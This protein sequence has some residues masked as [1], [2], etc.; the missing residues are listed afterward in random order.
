MR[1]KWN[2]SLLS[3]IFNPKG[4]NVMLER[5]FQAKLI[6][7]IKQRFD[8]CMVIKNDPNYIQGLPDLLVLYR[9][10]WAALEC[11]QS[12]VASRRPN[13]RYYIDKMDSMS[14]ARFISPSNKEEV[15]NDL[16]RSFEA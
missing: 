6:K 5:T 13:Q 7:D 9:D 16:Q 15:L 4:G 14:F 1:E 10:K 12:D 3:I 11:K 2:M 8:G